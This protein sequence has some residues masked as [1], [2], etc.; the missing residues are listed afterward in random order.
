MLALLYVAP[1]GM[2]AL[3]QALSRTREFAADA[4]AAALTGD[5]AALAEALMALDRPAPGAGG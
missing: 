4:G 5:P 3:R 2:I 1:V